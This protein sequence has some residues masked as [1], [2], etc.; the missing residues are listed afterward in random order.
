MTNDIKSELYHLIMA[1]HFPKSLL[2]VS[3]QYQPSSQTYE[4]TV[5]FKNGYTA[6]CEENELESKTFLAKCQMIYDL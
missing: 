2:K 5:M 6:S 1:R 4:V 3:T